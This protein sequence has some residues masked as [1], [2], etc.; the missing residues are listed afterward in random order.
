MPDLN[1]PICT[2]EFLYGVYTKKYWCLHASQAAAKREIA[3]K[4]TKALMAEYTAAALKDAAVHEGTGLEYVEPLR[5]TAD[6]ILKRNPKVAWLQLVLS[7]VAPN[8]IVFSRNYIAPKRTSAAA[9]F[10]INV[11]NPNGFFDGLPELMTGKRGSK[12]RLTFL[13]REQVQIVKLAKAKH[14]MERAQARFAALKG[15]TSDSDREDAESSQQPSQ[16]LGQTPLVGANNDEE[17]IEESKEV[18]S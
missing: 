8:H 12:R 7:T 18:N 1:D 14:Q 15:E 3:T 5:A 13:N 17:D 9:A 16:Q 10:E 2:V 6:L 4:P 11:P